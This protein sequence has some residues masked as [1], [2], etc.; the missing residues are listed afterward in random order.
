MTFRKTKNLPALQ[1]ILEML[2][3]WPNTLSTTTEGAVYSLVF[4]SRNYGN[5]AV[6][7]VSL[8]VQSVRICFVQFIFQPK[9]QIAHNRS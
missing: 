9:S 6:D 4:F 7:G 8:F 5:L 3:S 2:S 1:Q